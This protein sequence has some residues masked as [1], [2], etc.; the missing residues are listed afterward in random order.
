MSID[1]S[2]II[3]CLNEAPHLEKNVAVVEEVLSATRFSYELI[4]IDEVSEDETR[5]AVSRIAEDARARGVPCRVV[6]H[7]E[8]R[9]RGGT[10]MEGLRLAQGRMAGF[11]DIDLEVSAVYLPMLLAEIDSGR[12]EVA[13]VGRH[14]SLVLTPVFILRHILSVGYRWLAQSVLALPRLDTETGYKFFNRGKILPIIDECVHQ[15]WFWDTEVMAL[16]FTHGLEIREQPGL[17]LRNKD[18]KSTV[19]IFR[20]TVDYFKALREFSARHGEQ[21]LIAGRRQPGLF[22]RFPLLYTLFM[23]AAYRKKSLRERFQKVARRIEPGSRVVELCC[24]Q[25]HLYLSHLKEVGADYTGLDL[26][27]HFIRPL[28]NCGANCRVFDLWT[29]EIPRADYVIMMSSLYHFH[30]RS[31]EILERMAAAAEKEVIITEPVHNIL[32]RSRSWLALILARMADPG[33]GNTTFR[34]T[35]ESLQELLDGSD[36]EVLETETVSQGREMVAVIKGRG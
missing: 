16:A 25:G 13:I 21:L 24:G 18:K 6:L 35:P 15:G 32:G 7:Q 26:N 2:L 4:F 10:V 27:P 20:D 29:E 22:Y 5:E 8:R 19:R 31:A 14:Y 36:L 23:K 9:G 28:E 30:P 33:R 17:F 3:P 12:A 34:Y 11:L 1:L